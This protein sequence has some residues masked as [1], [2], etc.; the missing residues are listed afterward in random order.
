[1]PF[2]NILDIA[3]KKAFN[4]PGF[5]IMNFAERMLSNRVI[6]ITYQLLFNNSY[7]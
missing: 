4:Y 1:M 5:Q 6:L 2:R 7:N 3:S